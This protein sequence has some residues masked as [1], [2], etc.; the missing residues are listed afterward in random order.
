MLKLRETNETPPDGFRYVHPT[1]GRRIGPFNSKHDWLA[2]IRKHYEDNGYPLP[3]DWKEQAEDQM[4]R[5]LPPGWGVY[6]DGRTQEHFVD[7][8]MGFDDVINGTNVFVQFVKQGT[9]LVDQELAEQRGRICSA[10]YYNQSIA[11][12]APCRGLSNLVEEVAQM[13]KTEADSLLQSKSCL[14]C[15]CVSRAHIWM[16]ANVLVHGVTGAMMELFPDFCWKKK[17]IRAL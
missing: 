2:A 13:R 3:E 10:C 14:V 7:S 17:E 8:R 1:D 12:C 11:G 16:P 9:P 5:V 4:A 6:P 15:K